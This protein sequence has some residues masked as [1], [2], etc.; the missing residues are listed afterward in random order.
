MA[1]DREKARDK[2]ESTASL[3]P[4]KEAKE[5][6]M[7]A[8]KQL[9]RDDLQRLLT[10]EE[11]SKIRKWADTHGILEDEEMRFGTAAIPTTKSSE[12]SS[13]E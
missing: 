11:V 8:M 12:P 9:I 7:D 4:A 13:E 5:T 2:V 3:N 6:L 10:P 1:E